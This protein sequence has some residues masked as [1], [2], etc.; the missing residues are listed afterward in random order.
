MPILSADALEQA[1]LRA[2]FADA[3]ARDGQR[4]QD[5]ISTAIERQPLALLEA[6]RL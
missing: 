2:V 4:L 3:A 1:V 5:E 6:L